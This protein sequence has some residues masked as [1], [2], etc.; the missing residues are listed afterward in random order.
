MYI[1]EVRNIGL[2]WVMYFLVLKLVNFSNI[3]IKEVV[4]SCLYFGYFWV[5]SI[6]QISCLSKTGQ[7]VNAC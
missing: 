4:R 1:H 7:Q 5:L 3:E 6:I 2:K